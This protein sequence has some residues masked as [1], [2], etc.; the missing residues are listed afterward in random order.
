MPWLLILHIA[1]LLCWSGSLLYLPALIVS[2]AR[3]DPATKHDLFRVGRGVF[4]LF[5]TPAAL[6]TI[7]SGTALIVSD[8]RTELWLAAKLT[9]VSG[10][11]I[12]HVLT[13]RLTIYVEKSV[14]KHGVLFSFLLGAVSLSLLAG[15][16]W[17]V[18]AEPF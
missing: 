4:T 13:G 11:V 7:V 9:L 1:A 14:S 16:L 12:C 17:L 5:T 10:L 15:I 6:L 2:M 8:L 3:R 18:L